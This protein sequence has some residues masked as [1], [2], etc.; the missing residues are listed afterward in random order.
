[1]GR[2]TPFL[3]FNETGSPRGQ[4]VISLNIRGKFTIAPM[5]CTGHVMFDIVI[6][7]SKNRQFPHMFEQR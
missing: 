4:I 3:E 1:M 7:S 6:L 2:G 5:Q